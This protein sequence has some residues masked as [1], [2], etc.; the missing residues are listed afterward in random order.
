MFLVILMMRIIF[1][2]TNTQVLRLLKVFAKD[3]TSNVK[4][5]KL[6]LHK[7]GQSR[8]IL[9]RFL[10]SLLKT[11]QRLMKNVLKP[12]VKSFFK[13]ITINSSS[14]SNRWSCF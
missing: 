6:L 5:S 7:I 3:L 12:P 4:L 14:I 2:I 13:T 10:W 1:H 8:G 9:G 11:G